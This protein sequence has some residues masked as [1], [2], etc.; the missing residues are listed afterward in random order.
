LARS[1]LGRIKTES[2]IAAEAIATFVNSDEW[3]TSEVQNGIADA[4]LRRVVD[5]DRVAKW[6]KTWG[7]DQLP[8]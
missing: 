5:H 2:A 6:L 4:D 1:Q 8:K 3:Q 7:T